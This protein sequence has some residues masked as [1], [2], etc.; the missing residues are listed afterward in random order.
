MKKNQNDFI[1]SFV[2]ELELTTMVS[3]W[4]EGV[5]EGVNFDEKFPIEVLWRVG[6]NLMITAF[7]MRAFGIKDRDSYDYKS[8]WDDVINTGKKALKE[9]LSR[10]DETNSVMRIVVNKENLH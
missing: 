6:F 1:D 8:V 10:M 5:K 2:S 3:V 7:A 9:K 4:R